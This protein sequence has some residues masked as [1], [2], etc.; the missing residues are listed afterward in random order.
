MQ[1]KMFKGF[2]FVTVNPTEYLA[3][4]QDSF[5]ILIY[6]TFPDENHSFKFD[7]EL[8]RRMDEKF[9]DFKGVKVLADSFGWGDKDGF[10][11]MGEEGL[12]LPRV[13]HLPS[14]SFLKK[15]NVILSCPVYVGDVIEDMPDGERDVIVHCAFHL[16]GYPHNIRPRI[17]D[18]LRRDFSNVTNFDRISRRQY[19]DFL[20]RTLISVNAPGD[21]PC[22]DTFYYAIKSG[23]LTFAEETMDN[24]K[25]LPKD[26]LIEGEHYVSFSLDTLSEKLRYLL[27]NPKECDRIR[28]SGHEKLKEGYDLEKTSKDFHLVLENLCRN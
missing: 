11:R 12:K 16:R 24:H 10:E 15:S 18:V 8:V 7:K 23:A 1:A 5:D 25:L 3:I 22:S 27:D 9:W 2:S 6:N 4:D 13:K 26:T 21:G 17:M 14:F 28:K 20:R 19:L